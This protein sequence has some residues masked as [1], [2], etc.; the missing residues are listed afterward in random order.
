[1]LGKEAIISKA[2]NLSG[3]RGRRCGGYKWESKMRITRGGLTEEFF[4]TMNELGIHDAYRK[5]ISWKL[6][7]CGEGK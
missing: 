1:M 4:C 6:S 5:G 7:S 2:R 3:K